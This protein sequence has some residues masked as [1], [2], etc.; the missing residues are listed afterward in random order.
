LSLLSHPDCRATLPFDVPLD[1]LVADHIEAILDLR[2]LGAGVSAVAQALA[3]LGV[4]R[5]GKPVG[6]G[7]PPRVA[8]H[9]ET[10][11]RRFD[12]G[13]NLTNRIGAGRQP[14]TPH[15]RYSAASQ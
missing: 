1:R 3:E 2:R 13:G 9:T 12:D 6:G 8:D 14:D 11:R 7:R 5:D 10:R 15:V 4:T